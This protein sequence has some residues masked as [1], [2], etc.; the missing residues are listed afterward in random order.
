MKSVKSFAV[1]LM[2]LLMLTV[3]VLASDVL[4]PNEVIM[5]TLDDYKTIENVYVLPKGSDESLISK[6]AFTVSLSVWGN[7]TKIYTI[8]VIAILIN[9]TLEITHHNHHIFL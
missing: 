6:D 3:N 8:L 7:I 4:V 9:R 2:A 1:I 5:G